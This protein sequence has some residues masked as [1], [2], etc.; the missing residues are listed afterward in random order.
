MHLVVDPAGPVRCD[1]RRGDRPGRARAAP[2]IA[3]ASHVEP[4][5]DGRWH[6]RPPA[7]RRAGARPL[8]PPQR[9]PGGRAGLA[10]GELA[11]ALVLNPPAANP[12]VRSSDAGRPRPRHVASTACRGMSGPS[13]SRS[14]SAP[15]DPTRPRAAG[16]AGR[17]R[18]RS[19]PTGGASHDPGP[20]RPRGRRRHR[21]V[22]PHHP[23]PRV[24]GPARRP[25]RPRARCRSTWSSTARSA[26][27]PP[28]TP[29]SSPTARAR[30]PSAPAATRASTSTSATST[31]RRRSAVDGRPD[32]PSPAPAMT[33]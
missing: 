23:P 4:D 2:T 3:R 1:L 11:H 16:R 18:G 8:R 33:T 13:V 30:W 28:S 20:A 32:H 9:G 27:S 21:R 31:W 19:H 12:E 14:P 25:G 24:L 17:P 22:D 6:G 15:V 10:G 29:A 26:A 7:R 5:R